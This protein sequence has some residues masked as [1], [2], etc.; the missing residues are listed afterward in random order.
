MESTQQMKKEEEISTKDNKMLVGDFIVL[1]SADLEE[2]GFLQADMASLRLGVQ[3]THVINN[4]H[5]FV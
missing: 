5:S 2:A 4:M 1:A 3:E